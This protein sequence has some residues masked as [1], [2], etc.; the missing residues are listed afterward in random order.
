MAVLRQGGHRP[1]AHGCAPLRHLSITENLLGP[2]DEPLDAVVIA[3]VRLLSD[4]Q[5][6]FVAKRYPPPATPF[7][8]TS[9]VVFDSVGEGVE[10]IFP[11]RKWRRRRLLIRLL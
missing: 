10:F 4:E 5:L 6:G 7:F 2:V 3:L 8:R 11:E 9:H 1:R